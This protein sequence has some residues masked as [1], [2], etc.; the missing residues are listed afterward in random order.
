MVLRRFAAYTYI[1]RLHVS[2]HLAKQLITGVILPP[3]YCVSK[4][5]CSYFVIFKLVI[6]CLSSCPIRVYHFNLCLHVYLCMYAC[7]H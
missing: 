5:F 4:K 1:S 3:N 7:M 2:F 6:I